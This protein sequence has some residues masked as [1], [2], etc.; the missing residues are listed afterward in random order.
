MKGPRTV[1][2]TLAVVGRATFAGVTISGPGRA[3]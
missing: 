3:T 1:A 2:T